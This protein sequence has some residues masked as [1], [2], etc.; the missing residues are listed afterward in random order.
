MVFCG[1]ISAIV[2]GWRGGDGWGGGR[3]GGGV[4]LVNE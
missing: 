1:F 2:D 3:G 4:N